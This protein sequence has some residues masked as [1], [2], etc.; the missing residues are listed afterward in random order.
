MALSVLVA[1]ILTPALCASLLKPLDASH[2]PARPF[3]LFNRGFEALARRYDLTLSA[4]VA[5]PR[6]AFGVYAAIVAGMVVLFVTLPTAFL[7]AEDQGSVFSTFS[8]P[9][10]AVQDRTVAVAKQIERY[11][12]TRER[13]NV[14]TLF[15]LTGQ[16][17]GGAGQ[18]QGQAFVHLRPWDERGGARNSAQ[19]I[20]DRATAVF[21]RIRDAQVF[22]V[23]PPALQALGNASGFDLEL[24]DRAGLGHQALAAAQT[25]LI[26]LANKDP[27]LTGVRSGDLADTPQLHVDID[28]VRAASLGLGEGDINDTISAAWGGAFVNN[29]ID[30]GRVK[31]V[32]MQADAPFRSRIDDLG[33]WYVRGS[34][35]QMAPFSAF[36]TWRWTGGPAQLERYNGAAA[37]EVEGAPAH[38]VSTGTAMNEIARL[39]GKLPH[40]IGLEWTGISTQEQESGAQAPAL[41]GLSILVVF[42]CL[43]GLYES[44][45]A[46]LSVMLVIPLGVVGALLAAKLR[47]FYNDVYFQVGMLTTIGLSAKN[48][49]LIVQFAHEAALR[50]MRP[51][52]AAMLA[53]RLRL[54]PIVMTSMAF[55]AGV[56]PLAISSGPGAGS[57]NDIGTGVIGGMI[58]ATLLAVFFVP[59]FYLTVRGRLR[60]SEPAP[61]PA[62]EPAEAAP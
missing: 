7:P 6:L 39:V 31:Q 60:A 21:D 11:Y 37:M 33:R 3:R 16:S 1:L 62:G 38:D 20:A 5:R 12:L 4:F 51:R 2:R 34:S 19:A 57:Q 32:Y 28:P 56:L 9:S 23:V 29:F 14:D 13:G 50:G 45:S 25:Q 17:F 22:N 40:G 47:G 42:L 61:G 58:S 59:L 54:R 24:E 41:Y 48:A 26:D 8:L 15:V 10:G 53:A 52:E 55:I 30:R 44:W 27:L 35:G 18:N 46:P 49:I 36:A 43:A